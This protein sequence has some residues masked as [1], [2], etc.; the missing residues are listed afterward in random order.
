LD[1]R[2]ILKLGNY[3]EFQFDNGARIIWDISKAETI[4]ND[5]TSESGILNRLV[6]MPREQA[7]LLLEWDIYSNS[8][9]KRMSEEIRK[10]KECGV[11]FELTDREKQFFAN[12]DLEYPKRCKECREARKKKE[13]KQ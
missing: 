5:K 4:L 1:R 10:C 7:K 11:E 8:E 12:H 6:E 13:A 3:Y 9:E 2:I